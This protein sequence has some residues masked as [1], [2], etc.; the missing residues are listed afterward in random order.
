MGWR[1]DCALQR[2]PF[3][4][5]RLALSGG[6]GVACWFDFSDESLASVSAEGY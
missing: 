2:S 1:S 4:V 5:Q 3:S 6:K